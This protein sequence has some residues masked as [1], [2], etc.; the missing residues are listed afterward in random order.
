MHNNADILAEIGLVELE[1]LFAV[2][3]IFG[4]DDMAALEFVTEARV[5]DDDPSE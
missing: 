1:E 2:N 3:E 5:K 4:A